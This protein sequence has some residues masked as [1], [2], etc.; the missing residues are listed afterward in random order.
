[1][2]TIGETRFF[3]EKSTF[4]VVK[5]LI[6]R[7]NLSNFNIWSLGCSTGEEPYSIAIMLYEMGFKPSQV[8]IYASDINK[9]FIEK[10]KKGIYER[11]KIMRSERK[12]ITIYF[13]KIDANNYRLK[14]EIREYVKFFCL[15][16]FDFSKYKPFKEMFKFIFLRNVLIYFSIEK[17]EEIIDKIGETLV[18]SGYLFFGN[19]EV[20]CTYSNKYIKESIGN[21]VFYRKRANKEL[22]SKDQFKGSEKRSTFKTSHTNNRSKRRYDMITKDREIELPLFS[23][24][25]GDVLVRKIKGFL[26]FLDPHSFE[27]Y[28]L[29]GYLEEVKGNEHKAITFYKKAIEMEPEF[30]LSH[31]HLGN[32]YYNNGKYDEAYREYVYALEGLKERSKLIKFITCEDVEFIK[33]F[34][35]N[36]IGT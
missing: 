18:E 30:P 14:G 33:S 13:E 15:D 16:I 2:K 5:S 19:K 31:L 8:K 32:I 28:F 21:V 6:K 9:E 35:E 29:K 36:R 27:Y 20:L 25:K 1:M 24:Y 4:N 34:L 3:R 26:Y 17:I 7:E 22:E 12:D 23:S 10:A 11:S